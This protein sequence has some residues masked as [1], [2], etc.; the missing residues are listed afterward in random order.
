MRRPSILTMSVSRR[1]TAHL[2]TLFFVFVM[3][4]SATL[5]TA[6]AIAAEIQ[7]HKPL[8]PASEHGGGPGDTTQPIG[9]N[10]PG[11]SK[12]T[13]SS[14]TT[15]PRGSLANNDLS[16]P[17]KPQ[18][19]TPKAPQPFTTAESKS[20]KTKTKLR[21]LTE[22]RTANSD[23][24]KNTDGSYTQT[25][26]L[27]PKY[28]QKDNQWQT[29]DTTLVEDK[30][31]GDSDNPF[32][33]LYG[34]VQSA[35]DAEQ[36]FIVKDNKWQVRFG[37]SD[38][39]GG[40]VRIKQGVEQIGFSPV[41][42]KRVAPVV[43]T[44]SLG[45][46]IVHYYD[47]WPG[48]NVEYKVYSA[49]LKENI[50][51]KDKNA[52]TNFEF[53]MIGATLE[54]D[55]TQ[56]GGFKVKGVLNDQFSVRPV[57]LLLAD[58]GLVTDP[59]YHQTYANG[60]IHIAVDEGYVRGLQASAFPVT[61]DPDVYNQQ[62]ISTDYIDFRVDG[63][64][65]SPGTCSIYA[66]SV[67]VG[68]W[69]Q[70]RAAV[71]V[72][73]NFLTADTTLDY[74]DIFLAQ[75][76]GT[77][78]TRS[79]QAAH[80]SC[81]N[82]FACVDS[83]LAGP[84][85]SFD[86][87]G[88]LDVTNIYQNRLA[89]NDY[90][91]WLM[92]LGQ[93]CGCQSYKSFDPNY[94]VIEF[95]YNRHPA[96]PTP[97]APAGIS[98]TNPVT[99]TTTQPIIGV[100]AAVDPDGDPVKYAFQLQ[101]NGVVVYQTDWQD[102]TRLTVPEGLLQDGGTYQLSYI[103]A[104]GSWN[105]GWQTGGTIKVD[106][107]TGK[108]KTS[109][110]DDVGPV[111]VSLNTGNVF[112]SAGT[113]TI[114]ALGGDIGVGLNY[115]SPYASRMGV[116]AEYFNNETLS[117]DPSL[118]R[119]ESTIDNNWALGSPSQG[120]I[121]SDHF[122][123]RYT[124]YFVA[125]TTGS[126]TF[127]ASND[128]SL[129]ITVNNQQLYVNG[130]CYGRCYGSSISL[131]AGQ[132]VPFKVEY[133]EG[134]VNAYARIYVKG[135]VAEDII[136][137]QWLRTAPMPTDQNTGLTG[138]Y[139]VDNGSHDP[140]QMTEQFMVRQ[141]PMV[142]FLWGAAPPVPGALSD[143]FYVRWDGY[144]TP[145]A[146]G[147]HYFGIAS[148]DGGR[149]S[150]NGQMRYSQWSGGALRS[151]VDTQGISLTAGVP[152]PISV[153]FYEETGPADIQLLVKTPSD[154]PQSSVAH[155]VEPQ[156]LSPG[157]RFL[158]AGWS[159]SVDATGSLAYERLEVR[160]NGDIMLYD[161]DGSSHLFT[162]TG[163][164]YKP[165]V[166]EAGY[167]LR[168]ANNTYTLTDTD[169]RTYL[170]G[171]D[172]LLQE[173][174]TPTDDRNPAALKYEYE[175][176]DGMSR[177]H[178]ILDGVNTS[179]KGTLYYADPATNSC[180]T[181]PS[182]FDAP[183][184]YDLCAFV[185]T[186][187]QRTDLF[188]KGGR[189]ARLTLPGNTQY[190]FGYELTSGQLSTIRSPLTNDAIAAGVRSDTDETKTML[191][192]DLLARATSVKAPAPTPGVTRSEHTLDYLPGKSKRHITGDPEPNGYSQY[193]E[194]DDLLRTTK[195]CDNLALCATSE[196]DAT[197]D[198]PL[199]STD[200]TGFK[201]TTIYNANDLPTDQYGPAP[202]A[203]YNADR[204]PQTAYAAQVPHTKTNYDESIVGPAV[205]WSCYQS[206]SPPTG[207]AVLG[208]GK[209]HS[210]GVVNNGTANTQPG[211]L[212]ATWTSDP[213]PYANPATNTTCNN[214][215]W[216]ASLT[217]K[218]TLPSTGTYDIYIQHT[219]GARL[220]LNDT[221]A[222]N[223]W[224]DGLVRN[225]STYS[226]AYTAGQA[227]VRFKLDFY[228]KY[229]TATPTLKAY[230]RQQ[231]GFGYTTNWASYLSPDYGLT[232]STVAYDAALG[233]LTTTVN[234]GSNPEYGL[235][236]SS[237]LDPSGLN[238]T[239]N[240]TYETPGAS[241]SFL[242]Q[243]SRS[244]PGSPSTNPTFKYAYYTATETRDN[245]CTTGTTEAY[246]QAGFIKTKT[247]ADPDNNPATTTPGVNAGR[248]TETIYDDAGRIVATRYNTESWT[249]ITYDSRGRV[250]QTV[251]PAF[252]G[253]ASRTINTAY[254]VAGDP[255]EVTTWDNN[256][257]LV[258]W[259]DLLGRTVK[260]RDVHDDETTTTYDALGR[261]SQRV[262]ALGT[263]T[264]VYDN[265]NRLTDQKLDNTIYATVAYDAYNRIDHVDYPNAGQQRLTLARDT[266]GRLNT[267]TYRLG[268]GTTTV[269]DTVNRSQS[270]Q[271]TSDVVQSGANQLWYS[272]GYDTAGR[273]TSAN[274]GPHSYSYGFGAQNAGCTG[275][276]MNANSGKNSNRTTQTIDGVSN[277]F[278]YD[279]ADRLVGGNDPASNYAE[280]DP[281]GS[282]TFLGTNAS[283]LRMCYDSSD[284]NWCLVSYG[285]SNGNGVGFYYARDV[286]GRVVY[287]EKDTINAWNWSLTSYYRY[288]YTGSGDSPDFIRDASWNIVEKHVELP[289]GVILTIYPT[290]SGNAQKQYSLPNI[291]EDV[292]IT[293]NAAGT[294]TSTG[295]GPTNSFTYDPFGNALS[296]STLPSNTIFGS[297]GWLGRNQKLIE[298]QVA[299]VPVQMGARIYLPTLGR[300]TQTDP[301]E[302]GTPNKYVYPTNPIREEDVSGK[303]AF[304]ILCF[305]ARPPIFSGRGVPKGRGF[306]D[307]LTP[308]SRIAPR[309]L[310]PGT[311]EWNK[312]KPRRLSDS[313]VKKLIKDG[314][315]EDPHKI[316]EKAGGSSSD[317]WKDRYDNLYRGP[318]DPKKDGTELDP[319]WQNLNDIIWA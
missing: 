183:P 167:L 229:G 312:F 170:F 175:I 57:N 208:T 29:V 131:Q 97:D 105:S 123:A 4:C 51:L 292:L 288:G 203:W 66:G 8:G 303:C 266:L 100:N 78:G 177:L 308:G 117:G 278:C 15:A 311:K 204:T 232:T 217:G 96:I 215:G 36:A 211:V 132:V 302:G 45:H 62:A 61:V 281:H 26:Y 146:S 109:T 240:S 301:I 283:P 121:Q 88:W 73:Y 103:I 156:Y 245:P 110:Y 34:Q 32:G 69:K 280:Y 152:V 197:K 41:G 43:T 64:T 7:T 160:Q 150:V 220:F 52:T 77:V 107:R 172:G 46:Q 143:H 126:Y 254:A 253:E 55:T 161:A 67:N 296:G 233:N 95:Y 104:N 149:V 12:D 194:Y 9:D 18:P 184:T 24:F 270:N 310:K 298:N 297:Y 157:K 159:P 294:N 212:D 33:K 318:H 314:K 222:I 178:Y 284:R 2:T 289:G 49:Q 300:F 17:S 72:P 118:R 315:L 11:P 168:N 158:P 81:L 246:K 21:E 216:A 239:S 252:N 244:L 58:S 255:L 174:T 115:N 305:W 6:S 54:A 138:H 271:I 226:L 267:L 42:A 151:G 119:T 134:T 30:N 181:P 309:T 243:T 180:A 84:P 189:L 13:A 269:S 23:V 173:T 273:L 307:E 124:G 218:L 210:T 10:Y 164:G 145:Q 91:A 22:K 205:A 207:G 130:G 93:E 264:F 75:D 313:E 136:N 139:Y 39:S 70:W 263:E 200:A 202:A 199:S 225:S 3:L 99:V 128:D 82:S 188:Y 83:A 227:P 108:D 80:A 27:A 155:P 142:N 5:P 316:K 44:D 234:Y 154:D 290:Q 242:R 279:Y 201:S 68:G 251:V 268:D 274:I 223:D 259:M 171:V 165:P 282:M 191:A 92:L 293:T 63:P 50:I 235:A 236:Q 37:P 192:Y 237:T 90:G 113:H 231:G 147:L 261:V 287:R 65:C 265:Y 185:T 74:A 120:T 276:N 250:T 141:D 179:R 89:L 38:F 127:G 295:N 106:L 85:A 228:S 101:S 153:E 122:S 94:S 206:V 238:L 186:D 87:Y 319:L 59:V 114:K 133:A 56:P 257:W 195:A 275:G 277:Y 262:S 144:F 258:T 112:T 116:T 14:F 214:S 140:A 285:S 19:A 48:V 256:G 224:S 71:H 53:S 31:A 193:I 182:G 272:Y 129:S 163:S 166:N 213:L 176:K 1:L 260:Y 248:I 76:G 169:G 299:L 221:Q 137:S 135:A 162:N 16:G 20:S 286:Q 209:L 35:V 187:N 291:H 304:L 98:P 79:F 102:P 60:K 25:Y 306:S 219:E 230:I 148:D 111:S 249:C 198:L 190:D 247:E 28:Y 241:G 125:P 317:I 40:M 196:W 47:L 86:S